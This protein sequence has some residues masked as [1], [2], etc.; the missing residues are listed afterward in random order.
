MYNFFKQLE[1]HNIILSFKGKVTTELLSS[2]YNI[3][4]SRLNETDDDPQRKKKFYHILVESLQNV[5]HHMEGMNRAQNGKLEKE[6]MFLVGYNP[7]TGYRIL[8]GNFMSSQD[9][10]ALNLNLEKITKL[11][12]DELGEY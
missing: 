6:A 5:F 8:T 12:P 7:E 10:P 11:N 2:V 4:E 1:E 9:V 3:M